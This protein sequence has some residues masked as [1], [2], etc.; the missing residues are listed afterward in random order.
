LEKETNDKFK[1]YLF[2]SIL[3]V[4][5]LK[6]LPDLSLTILFVGV[7]IAAATVGYVVAWWKYRKKISPYINVRITECWRNFD[8]DQGRAQNDAEAA[9][10]FENLSKC[11][12]GESDYDRR[13]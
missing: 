7:M 2:G 3:W 4:L 1:A 11:L 8:R 13:R 12:R 6:E 10:A 5:Q 9:Q